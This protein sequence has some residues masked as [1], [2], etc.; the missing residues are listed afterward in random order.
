MRVIIE[1]TEDVN[2][3]K[4]RVVVECDKD[5]VQVDVAVSLALRALYA[6][7]YDKAQVGSYLRAMMEQI[8]TEKSD[9]ENQQD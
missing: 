9:E 2:E 6:Y 3:H 1:E 4:E 8:Q 5:M 7:G